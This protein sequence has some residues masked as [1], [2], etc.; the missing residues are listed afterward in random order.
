MASWPM[1]RT[2]AAIPS[3]MVSLS[4]MIRMRAI[5]PDDSDPGDQG[6]RGGQPEVEAGAPLGRPST[7]MAPP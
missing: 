3:R 4:S 6:R 2:V 5:G 1:R 7:A